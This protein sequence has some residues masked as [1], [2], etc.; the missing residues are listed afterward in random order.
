M[1][2]IDTQ[3]DVDFAF[4]SVQTVVDVARLEY[5]VGPA[6]KALDFLNQLLRYRFNLPLRAFRRVVQTG[7]STG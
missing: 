5:P 4:R 7:G 2:P 6:F 1:L 3:F